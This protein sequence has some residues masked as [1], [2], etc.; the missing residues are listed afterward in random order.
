MDV[1]AP[2][3]PG[4]VRVTEAGVGNYTQI[5]TNGRHEWAADE[6]ESVGGH[7]AGPNPYELL[8]ASLAACAT[9]TMRMYA[10]RKGWP[11]EGVSV[12]VKH[13]RIHAKDCEDCETK[14]GMIDRLEKTIRI[15][16]DL[17]EDQIDRLMEIA[18]RCPV[19]RTL[20]REIQIV[21]VNGRDPSSTVGPD[22]GAPQ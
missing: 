16:G 14:Q 15:I 18:D 2:L 20:S 5:A 11:L 7:D 1:T 12:D 8:S 21:S 10:D 4:A 9:I 6:P 3:E 13:D 22:D 19:H 17:D